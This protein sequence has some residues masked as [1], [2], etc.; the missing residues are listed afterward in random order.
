MQ[1]YLIVT[2]AEAA[3]NLLT[4]RFVCASRLPQETSPSILRICW[5]IHWRHSGWKPFARRDAESP[6]D[7]LRI[8]PQDSGF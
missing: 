4:C 6:G 2:R 3:V 7:A 1:D 5:L 8:W